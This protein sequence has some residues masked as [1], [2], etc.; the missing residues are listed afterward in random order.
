MPQA[1]AIKNENIHIS[2]NVTRL[3]FINLFSKLLAAIG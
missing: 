3:L 1:K 2:F